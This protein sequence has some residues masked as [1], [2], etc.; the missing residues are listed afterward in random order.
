MKPVETMIEAQPPKTSA[1]RG[2]KAAKPGNGHSKPPAQQ[3]NASEREQLVSCE[4]TIKHHF[5]TFAETGKA[6]QT[7]RDKRLYREHYLTFE[8]YCRGK[9]E[10]SKT[11]ANRL[12]A[13]FRVTEVVAGSGVAPITESQARPLTVLNPATQKKVWNQVVKEA[14]KGGT[15]ITAKLVSQVAHKVAPKAF[16]GRAMKPGQQRRTPSD[17]IRKSEVVEEFDNWAKRNAKLIEGS[18]GPE[19]VKLVRAFLK[20]LEA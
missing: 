4:N 3:L 2:S 20:G 12:I 11:Q 7:I 9:W 1:R 19:T 13:S 17:L 5:E 10:M 15:E 18:S 14:E 6:L 8:E 16:A